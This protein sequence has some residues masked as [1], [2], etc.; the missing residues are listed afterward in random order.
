MLGAAVDSLLQRGVPG[1]PPGPT[2]WVPSRYGRLRV[3]DSGGKGP[4]VL[5]TPDGPNVIEHHAEVVARLAPHAR[6]I[7]FDMPGFGFSK[8]GLRYDHSIQRG[9]ETVLSLMDALEIREASLHF[10]CANGFYALAAARLAPQRIRRLVLVQTPSLAAMRAWT[11]RR[12]P[13]AVRTPVL[14]QALVRAR[15]RFIAN[16]WYGVALPQPEARAPYRAIADQALCQGGCYC[17]AGVVQGLLKGRDHELAG[18]RQPV[19]LL[20]GDADATHTQTDPA[21]LHELVPQASIHRFAGC[22]HYA[23]LERTDDYVRIALDGLA[24]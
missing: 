19:T 5:M 22:G 1:T 24:A 10:S 14:G 23:D 20:W 17:L 7:C 11:D 3:Q 18:V 21:S 15:R 6:V 9:A 4:V 13:L 8:P 12:V 2:R 16:R